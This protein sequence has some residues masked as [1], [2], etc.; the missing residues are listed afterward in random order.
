MELAIALNDLIRIQ[1]CWTIHPYA[2]EWLKWK[3]ESL[4][5]AIL[6]CLGVLSILL[7][8]KTETK[9]NSAF[10]TFPIGIGVNAI[11]DLK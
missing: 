9:W 7:L 11:L 5:V 10:E 6:A 8:A 2:Y 1:V 4:F 3:L